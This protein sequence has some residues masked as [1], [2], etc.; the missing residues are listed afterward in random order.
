MNVKKIKKVLI[1]IGS[2]LLFALAVAFTTTFIIGKTA[3]SDAGNAIR[4]QLRITRTAN[5]ELRGETTTLER[6]QSDDAK[7][8]KDLEGSEQRL[9]ESSNRMEELLR[10]REDND[11]ESKEDNEDLGEILQRDRDTVEKLRKL[12]QGEDS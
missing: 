2:E 3:S 8:T 6:K 10:D 5:I 12:L 9:E 7:R 4:E 1:I 11:R